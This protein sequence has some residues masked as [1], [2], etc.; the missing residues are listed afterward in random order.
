MD[1]L[2]R[3]IKV[4]SHEAV[5]LGDLENN[6]EATKLVGAHLRQRNYPRR[7]GLRRGGRTD[8]LKR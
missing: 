8:T 6:S 1:E 5:N 7:G 4:D 2:R 3:F